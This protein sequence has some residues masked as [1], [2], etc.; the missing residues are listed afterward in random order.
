MRGSADEFRLTAIR[1]GTR[2]HSNVMV[3]KLKPPRLLSAPTI[4][5]ESLSMMSIIGVITLLE[6]LCISTTNGSSQPE[7]ANRYNLEFYNKKTHR[8]Q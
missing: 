7:M 2:I 8:M 3:S 4:W 6:F 1:R 5:N